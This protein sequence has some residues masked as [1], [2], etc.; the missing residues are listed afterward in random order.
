MSPSAPAETGR[1]R[2]RRLRRGAARWRGRLHSGAA[3]GGAQ[4]GAKRSLSPTRR[5]T[6][7]NQ[8]VDAPVPA[9]TSAA[10]AT[11]ESIRNMLAGSVTIST[12]GAAVSSRKIPTERNARIVDFYPYLAAALVTIRQLIQRA[13]N[14]YRRDTRPTIKRL[15]LPIAGS[16]NTAAAIRVVTCSGA[17]NLDR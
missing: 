9:T 15:K 12:A 8:R 7:R 2:R 17:G 1:K 11:V 13:R 16:S 6:E 5:S 4:A 3:D 14:R 10:V